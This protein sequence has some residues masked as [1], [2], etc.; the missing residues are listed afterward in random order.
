MVYF[1][2]PDSES[3]LAPLQAAA[4]T[5]R[6]AIHPWIGPV[7]ATPAAFGSRAGRKVLTL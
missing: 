4:C 6:I 5:Y 2:D 7:A 1:A 3:A